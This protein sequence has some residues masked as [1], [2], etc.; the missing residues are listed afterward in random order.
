MTESKFEEFVNYTL[1]EI[2]KGMN[3]PSNELNIHKV[4]FL[5]KLSIGELDPLIEW[6]KN[7]QAREI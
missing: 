3:I 7:E 6:Q 2:A 4:V 5:R 1:R